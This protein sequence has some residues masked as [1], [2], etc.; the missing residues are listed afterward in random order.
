[1]IMPS[2]SGLF[3]YGSQVSD[4][5]FQSWKAMFSENFM[6][7]ETI[8]VMLAISLIL[9]AMSRIASLSV[10]ITAPDFGSSLDEIVPPVTIIT[11]LGSLSF[12][13][14]GSFGEGA[15]VDFS[16][17]VASRI[18]DSLIPMLYPDFSF[19]RMIS[20]SYD[21]RMKPSQDLSLVWSLTLFPGFRFSV[22]MV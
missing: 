2:I 9:G 6:N 12:F 17:T 19:R 20:E 1:M 5:S 22:F 15:D 8:S 7:G 13:G 18:W 16:K 4:N 3:R 14:V 11:M 21:S 10:E